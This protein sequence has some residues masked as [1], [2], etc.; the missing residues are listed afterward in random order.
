[1][2]PTNDITAFVEKHGLKFEQEW[3]GDRHDHEA[4]KRNSLRFRINVELAIRGYKASM[5]GHDVKTAL[6]MLI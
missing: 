1:M 6:S 3:F 5:D 4:G 2:S